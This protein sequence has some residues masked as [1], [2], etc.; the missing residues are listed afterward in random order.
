MSLMALKENLILRRRAKHAVS[1]DAAADPAN[2]RFPD[3]IRCG[4]ERV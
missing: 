2:R 4:D 3:I 1:K